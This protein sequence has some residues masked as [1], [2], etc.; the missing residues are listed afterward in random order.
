MR[1]RMPARPTTDILNLITRLWKPGQQNT[2]EI[3]LT[4]T[5][6]N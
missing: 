4:N 6:V 3:N 5:N 1:T 2:M